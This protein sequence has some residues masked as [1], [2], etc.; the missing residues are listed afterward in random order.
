MLFFL[1]ID[2][3]MVPAKS[4]KAPECLHDGFP[5]FSAQASHV[6][7]QMITEED[8]VIL[9]TSHKANY[10]IATWKQIFRNRGLQIKNIQCLPE[11]QYHLSRKDEI[12][13][14]FNLN[15]VTEDVVIID[16]DTSLHALPVFLKERWVQTISSIGLTEVHMAIMQSL[17]REHIR[18]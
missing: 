3:V 5:A 1:D 13:N 16:D 11:N 8:T 10:S 7:Q 14:W 9:T 18:Y 17:C 2:G 12:V 4:W 15:H 6:L